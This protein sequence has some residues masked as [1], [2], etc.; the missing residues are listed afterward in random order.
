MYSIGNYCH[1]DGNPF[2]FFFKVPVQSRGNNSYTSVPTFLPVVVKLE[3]TLPKLVLWT[4]TAQLKLQSPN[5]TTFGALQIWG[6]SGTKGSEHLGK[7][8]GLQLN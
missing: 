5:K 7:C 6:T 1:F 4:Q 3:L 2:F 8:C